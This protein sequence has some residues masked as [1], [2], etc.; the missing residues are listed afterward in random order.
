MADLKKKKS[1]CTAKRELYLFPTTSH[2]FGPVIQSIAVPRE[3]DYSLISAELVGRL[4]MAGLKP[5]RI[6]QRLKFPC[7]LLFSYS[8]ASEVIFTPDGFSALFMSSYRAVCIGK[9]HVVGIQFSHWKSY[10]ERGLLNRICGLKENGY[11]VCFCF[12]VQNFCNKTRW[13]TTNCSKNDHLSCWGTLFCFFFNWDGECQ[14]H[15][16]LNETFC[17][18]KSSDEDSW[19]GINQPMPL[20]AHNTAVI[21]SRYSEALGGASVHLF[22]FKLAIAQSQNETPMRWK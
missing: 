9:L 7:P 20:S 19:W 2:D 14:N 18:H 4:S 15:I 3:W 10:F 22:L 16:V 13:N 21:A 5:K 8:L 11:F 17:V 12:T 1:E 6:W